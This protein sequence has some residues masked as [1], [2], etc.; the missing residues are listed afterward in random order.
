MPKPSFFAS[1]LWALMLWASVC[2]GPG[3]RA[4]VTE[5]AMPSEKGMVFHRWPL[6]PRVPGWAQDRELSVLNSINALAPNGSSFAKA[7]TVIYAKAVLKPNVPETQVPSLEQWVDKDKQDFISHV[8]GVKV[9]AAPALYTAD[10]KK[11]ISYTYS[12]Q[13]EGQWERVSYLEEG[14]FF[15]VFTLSSRSQSGLQAATKAYEG[16]LRMYKEK[17]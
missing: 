10:G 14:D 7:E 11:C 9:A 12:P 1:L 5:F 16:M 4:E 6:L 15:L 17:P 8:P 3:A 13:S 2:M